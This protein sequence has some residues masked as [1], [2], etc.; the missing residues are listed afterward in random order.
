M[1]TYTDEDMGQLIANAPDG[2]VDWLKH[3]ARLP[4]ANRGPALENMVSR[5]WNLRTPMSATEFTHQKLK[6]GGQ[7]NG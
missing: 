2:L 3:I 5:L 6:I 7:R 4:T 1:T